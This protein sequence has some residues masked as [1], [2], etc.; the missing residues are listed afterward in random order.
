MEAQINYFP[1]VFAK[2]K[3]QP[4]ITEVRRI[5]KKELDK[6]SFWKEVGQHGYPVIITDFLEGT[7]LE[8]FTFEKLIE[9]TGSLILSPMGKPEAT[10]RTQV[11][12]EERLKH[13]SM[14]V[15]TYIKEVIQSSNPDS[16][17][18]YFLYRNIQ[19]PIEAIDELSFPPNP[20]VNQE[21]LNPPRIWIGKDGTSSGLHRDSIDNFSIQVIGAKEWVVF[22][23]VDSPYLYL[24]DSNAQGLAFSDVDVWNSPGFDLNHFPLYKKATPLSIKVCA[25]ELLFLPQGWPHAVKNIGDA[26][27][28]NQ[29][30]RRENLPMVLRNNGVNIKAGN[31]NDS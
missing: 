18:K 14:T 23:P 17:Q 4:R 3:H 20:Y 5:S 9:K 10:T 7:L 6:K 30:M 15:E 16:Q 19:L 24:D 31:Q 28:I 2:L 29:W 25:G 13:R 21:E 27:M 1:E 11:Q 12:S 22:P 8:N 26:F